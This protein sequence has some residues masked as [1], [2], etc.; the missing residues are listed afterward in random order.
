[1]RRNLLFVF[2]LI[3]LGGSVFGQAKKYLFLEHFTNSRCGSCGA[4][5]PGFYTKLFATKHQGNYHHMTVH[6]SFPYSSC[7]FYSANKAD[8]TALTTS[9][10]ILSTPTMLI[11]GVTQKY[12]G[13]ITDADLSSDVGKTSPIEL[14]VKE[15]GTT[16]RDITVEVKTVGIKPSGSYKLYVV[17]V[18]KQIDLATPNGEKV[19]H[20]VLRK[21][22]S[23][24]AGD[25]INLA[26][27]GSSVKSNY[28]LSVVSPWVESQVYIL[29]WIED[30][31]TKEVLNSGTKFDNVSTKNENLIINSFEISPNPVKDVLNIKFDQNIEGNYSAVITNMFGKEVKTIQIRN[32]GSNMSISTQDL[33]KGI[34]FLRIQNGNKM[35]TKRWIK[36]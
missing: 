17:A 26:N 32:S 31:N 14:E 16:T 9:N 13:S 34:Y 23:G 7:V 10:N 35:V 15:S 18:E 27:T 28:T 2:S 20:N 33:V 5:N 3:V 12:V 1:M 6:P 25:N 11:N 8:N 36:A 4:A 22:V 29:A 30:I 19:H 21:I 24:T